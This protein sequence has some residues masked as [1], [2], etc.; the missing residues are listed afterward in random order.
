M[1]QLKC[2]RCGS[3]ELVLYET[4]HEHGQYDGGLFVN[5]EGQIQARGGATMRQGEVQPNLTRIECESCGH[6]WHPRRPF[7]GGEV[8]G[9]Q[10]PAESKITSLDPEAE[11]LAPED[12]K[13]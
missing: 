4:Y 13:D 2:H 3:P 7:T 5:D 1:R 6:D 10:F 8:D 12:R 9:A 11:R